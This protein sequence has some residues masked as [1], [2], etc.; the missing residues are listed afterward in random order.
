MMTKQFLSMPVLVTGG[1]GFI[2]SHL[3]KRLK[4]LG[5]KIAVLSARMYTNQ[6]IDFKDNGIKFFQVDLLNYKGL[7]NAVRRFRPK[8]IYHLAAE[9]NVRRDLSLAKRIFEVNT[10]GTI[11]LICALED[12]KFDCLVNTGTCEEYGDGRT[13]F[14]EKQRESPVSAYSVSKVAN[15]YFCSMLYRTQGLPIVTLRPFLTYGPGQS[16]NMFIPSLI[17]SC[18]RGQD[19]V[20]TAGK[21]T[22]EFNYI[23]DIIDGF[24]LASLSKKAIGEIINIGNGWEYRIIDV[25]RKIVELI[26]KPI[27]LKIGALPYRLGEA[28]LFYCYNQMAKRLI[29]WYPKTDLESGLKQTI[30]WYREHIC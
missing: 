28:N 26:G 9:V 23:D 14:E 20:M 16:A 24:I 1:N 7:K 3:V 25:A 17:K 2:G 21:Q 19:F 10:I 22:R 6:I 29:D 15:S 27:K 13:P 12:Y 8:I 18:L 4:N 30:A 11:N 5:A